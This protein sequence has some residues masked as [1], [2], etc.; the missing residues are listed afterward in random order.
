MGG[1]AWARLGTHGYAWVRVGARGYAWVRVDTH[2]NLGLL[3]LPLDD[4]LYHLL[5]GGLP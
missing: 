3:H 1:Y 4:L 2:V 5:I